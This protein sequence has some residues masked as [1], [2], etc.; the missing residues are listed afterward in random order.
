[1]I[2]ASELA[3]LQAA[4]LAS[5]DKVATISRNPNLGLASNVDG[6]VTDAFVNVAGLV[7]IAASMH[8]P[9]RGFMAEQAALLGG[10][11]SCQVDLPLTDTAGNDVNLQLKD[12]ITIAGL[13]LSV[14]YVS[15]DQSYQLHNAILANVVKA[16]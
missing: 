3:C 10:T 4:V 13:T 8:A 7:G 5:F 12:R 2:P 6:G 1:M 14:V 11:V 9:D 15:P 16:K